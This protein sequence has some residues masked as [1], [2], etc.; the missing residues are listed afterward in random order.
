MSGNGRNW[1]VG[2]KVFSVWGSRQ[3]CIWRDVHFIW[4]WGGCLGDKDQWQ[5][6]QLHHAPVNVFCAKQQMVQ[7]NTNCSCE[8]ERALFWGSMA[9]MRMQTTLGCIFIITSSR[10]GSRRVLCVSWTNNKSMQVL[11]RPVPDHPSW[12]PGVM[13]RGSRLKAR[14]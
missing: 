14:S 7:L 2:P 4:E 6:V 1:V 5:R 13:C 11:A 9:G 3:P 10:T 8:G 12:A